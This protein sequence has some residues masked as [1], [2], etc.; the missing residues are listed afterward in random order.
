MKNVQRY[1]QDPFLTASFYIFLLFRLEEVFKKCQTKIP[2]AEESKPSSTSSTA[3]PTFGNKESVDKPDFRHLK[4]NAATN[5]FVRP[6]AMVTQGPIPASSARNACHIKQ[7]QEIKQQ[8]EL[9]KIKSQSSHPEKQSQL[10]HEP[11]RSHKLSEQ[12]APSSLLSA[13]HPLPYNGCQP[14]ATFHKES[15]ERNPQTKRNL[16]LEEPVPLQRHKDVE[17][18]KPLITNGCNRYIASKI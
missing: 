9:R 18:A 12:V 10:L 3:I 5:N 1:K 7:P 16:G 2:L 17:T 13:R 8:N 11:A 14:S 15:K 4:P 6:L